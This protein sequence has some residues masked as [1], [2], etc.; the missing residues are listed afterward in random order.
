MNE[1]VLRVNAALARRPVDVGVRVDV[2]RSD[3]AQLQ[4]EFLGPRRR[5]DGVPRLR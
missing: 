5:G 2:A 1:D 4:C 3:P